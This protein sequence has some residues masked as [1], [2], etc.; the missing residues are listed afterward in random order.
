MVCVGL[1]VCMCLCLCPVSGGHYI[2][3]ERVVER[4]HS[5]GEEAQDS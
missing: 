5:S 1:C 3:L 4:S 2:D